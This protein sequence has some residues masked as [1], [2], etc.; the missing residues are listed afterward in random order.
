MQEL[1]I[2]AASPNPLVVCSYFRPEEDVL[3][4]IA[5]ARRVPRAW[6]YKECE[7]DGAISG[8]VHGIFMYGWSGVGPE[9]GLPFSYLPLK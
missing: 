3:K 8:N 2:H 9:S 7:R 4:K 5:A 1:S 6:F